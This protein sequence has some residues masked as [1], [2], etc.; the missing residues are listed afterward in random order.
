MKGMSKLFGIIV[1]VAVIG[2]SMTACGSESGVGSV[3]IA[4]I[5]S[6]YDGKFAMLLVDRGSTTQGWNML[7]I[8]GASATFNLLDW[9]NDRPTTLNEG[10]YSVSIV[11]AENITAL[12]N[13][14]YL[15]LGIILSRALSGET[16]SIG[17]GEFVSL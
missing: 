9:V 7:T 16:V 10:N 15:Y 8:T 1:L 3:T 14:Q 4:G 12:T 17:F 6:Q 13:E 2:L 11:I 5:P